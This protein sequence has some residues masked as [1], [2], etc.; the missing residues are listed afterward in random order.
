M[1]EKESNRCVLLTFS[2]FCE[3]IVNLGGGRFPL[4]LI[5]TCRASITSNP[6]WNIRTGI[7]I[8]HSQTDTL[9]SVMTLQNNVRSPWSHGLQHPNGEWGL[10][11]GVAPWNWCGDSGGHPPAD[12]HPHQGEPRPER[13]AI[14]F[15]G[16][17]YS[18]YLSARQYKRLSALLT[19]CMCIFWL[20]CLC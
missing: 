1:S 12:E 17:R 19:L 5:V 3:Q 6:W 8:A 9:M 15:R 16:G 14:V 4:W 20:P 2:C 11:S 7:C 10:E 13:C 18:I